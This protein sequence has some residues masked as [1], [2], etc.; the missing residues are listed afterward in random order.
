MRAWPI[1]ALSLML[2]LPP[3]TRTAAQEVADM[4]GPGLGCAAPFLLHAANG[5]HRQVVAAEPPPLRRA[6]LTCLAEPGNRKR[7]LRQT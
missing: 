1:A 5:A 6:M 4:Q 3:D 7:P 2:W